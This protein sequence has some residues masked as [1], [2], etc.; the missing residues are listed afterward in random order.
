MQIQRAL[1]QLGYPRNEISVY[2]TLLQ[3]GEGTVAEITRQVELPR[4]TT[5][6]VI[7]EL[8]KKGLVSRCPK[9]Q[10]VVWLAESPT[11]FL[12]DLHEKE[13]VLRKLLPELQS[14]HH[15]TKE[16][17]ILKYYSGRV[18]IAQMLEE[19]L[20]T[21]Y[22]VLVIG[23]IPHMSKYLGEE[24]VTDFFLRLFACPGQIKLI[25]SPSPVVE[26]LKKDY[27]G[28]H[29]KIAVCEE[30]G[31]QHAVYIVFNN[32]VCNI[33]LGTQESVGIVFEDQGMVDSSKLFFESLWKDCNK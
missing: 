16:K 5:Q 6:L 25:T 33:L 14:I 21:H 31:I 1:E 3:M 4:S 7:E 30:E 27:L 11:R 13:S 15:E 24:L 26:I 18:N 23:S 32:H 2:I 17:P 10:H 28:G 19:I 9:R 22:S 20:L 12:T 29:N 8:Q